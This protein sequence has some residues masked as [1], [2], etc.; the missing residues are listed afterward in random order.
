MA[1]AGKSYEEAKEMYPAFDVTFT[2]LEGKQG[3]VTDM[4]D[5]WSAAQSGAG[6]FSDTAQQILLVV[7]VLS[8][9]LVLV[10]PVTLNRWL[11]SPLRNLSNKLTQLS[12]GDTL[13]ELPEAG[14]G[15]EIGDIAVSTVKLKESL[16]VTVRQQTM[17]DKLSTPVL[18]CNKDYIITYANDITLETLKRLEKYLPVPVDKVVGSNI[19]ILY[20]LPAHL[21]GGSYKT[22]FAMGDEWLSLNA[23]T[24]KNARGESDGAFIDWNIITDQKLLTSNFVGQIDAISKSQAVIEFNMDGTIITANDNFLDTL[25]YTLEEIKGKHHSLFVEPVL[26]ASPEYQ[27]FWEALN[28]GQF[29]VA[30]YKRLGKGGKEIWIQASYNPILD[31]NKVPFKVVKYA[32]DVTKQKLA[33]ANYMGQIDAIGKSQAVIEFNMDGTIITANDN[34]LNT[35]GYSLDEV[36]G[37]HHS[38][39]VDAA[40]R[41]SPEYKAFWDNLGRGEYQSGEFRR[42]GR[43]GKEVWIQASY[44]PIM[45]MNGKPFKVVN[46]RP[47]L[48]RRRIPR[49][50]SPGR[51]TRSVSRRR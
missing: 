18:L 5:A 9:G 45:D 16:V 42:I 14:L 40:Y 37:K 10:V 46:M 39:F 30:E 36:A 12:T 50:I 2:D 13:V 8:L 4:M 17:L 1:A 20:K 25:G 47:T 23:T 6:S 22:E 38:L 51:L 49:Q 43:G 11:F 3:T 33:S 28:R 29:Q 35:L 31:M 32:T 44:N 15:N 21:D 41:A 19:T 24:L 26:K 7:F 48:R 34:F 27:Q